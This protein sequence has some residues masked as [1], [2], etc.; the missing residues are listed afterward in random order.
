M[1]PPPEPGWGAAG[2]LLLLCLA[3]WLDVRF[4]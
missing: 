4:G 1:R 2:V 3:A